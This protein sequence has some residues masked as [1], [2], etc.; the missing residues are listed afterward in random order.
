M[1]IRTTRVLVVAA[2]VVAASSCGLGSSS[3]FDVGLQKVALD[4]AFE[5]EKS[6]KPVPPQAA[7]DPVP[8]ASQAQVTIGAFPNLARQD[9]RPTFKVPD[10]FHVDCPEAPPNAAPKTIVSRSIDNLPTP[11]RY[12]HKEEGTFD[13]QGP[14]PVKGSLPP[15]S[16][17]DYVNVRKVPQPND[18]FGAP[19][20]DFLAFDMVTPL[21]G[22][23]FI[24]REMQVTPTALQLKRLTYRLG[25]SEF[26]FSPSPAITMMDIGANGGEGATWDSAGT[27]ISTKT[28]MIVRGGIV[29]RE[30]VNV[31]GTVYEAYKVRSTERVISLAATIPFSSMTD[32]AD[33]IS[34]VTPTDSPNYY[35]VATQ[36][37]GQFLKEETHTVTTIGATSLSIDGTSTVMSLTPRT[38][39]TVRKA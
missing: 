5:N 17:R 20:A 8:V 26:V 18:T 10:V 28:S 16:V 22:D 29:R 15:Y 7:F 4:L 24:K 36:H 38:D 11:G 21:G 9:P 31:C 34:G 13:L 23:D 32:D 14:I 37:G 35:W 19:V 27:D 3:G 25:G 6:E 30:L 2:S 33:D 1:R 39:I 12:L